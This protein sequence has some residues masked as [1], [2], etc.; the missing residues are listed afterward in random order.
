MIGGCSP[1]PRHAG[2]TRRIP[3]KFF[4]SFFQERSFFLSKEN[5]QKT[6]NHKCIRL[7]SIFQTRA[8]SIGSAGK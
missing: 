5:N 1:D 6:F 8:T 2:A 4:A 7:A 3:K